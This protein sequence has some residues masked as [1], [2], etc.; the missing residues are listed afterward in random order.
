M[1]PSAPL[2]SKP[3]F[4]ERVLDLRRELRRLL[5]LLLGLLQLALEALG[6]RL[7]LALREAGLLQLLLRASHGGFGLL[8]LRLDRVEGGR[9]AL[10]DRLHGLGADRARLAGLQAVAEGEGGVLA[11]RLLL[12]GSRGGLGLLRLRFRRLEVRE[13]LLLLRDGLL[14]FVELLLLVGGALRG[15]G[16]LLL[17][18]GE[19]LG[20]RLRRDERVVAAFVVRV[21]VFVRVQLVEVAVERLSRLAGAVERG[22]RGVEALAFVRVVLREARLLLP[23]GAGLLGERRGLVERLE[24]GLGLLGAALGGLELGLLLLEG[25]LRGAREVGLELALDEVGLAPG[26][27][28][29]LVRDLLH[30]LVDREVEE[31]H[32]DLAALL[33][34]A[35][36]ERVELAL[37]QDHR[38]REAVVVEAEDAVDLGAHLLDAVGD[39][40]GRAVRD[41]L[42]PLLRGL[43]GARGAR[44]PV[45][46]LADAELEHHREPLGAVADELLVV[47]AH[48]RDLAVEREDDRVDQR[49]LAGA[50]RAGDREEVE[51]GEVEL[52]LLPEGGEA[53]ERELVRP[54]FAGGRPLVASSWTWS[55]SCCSSSDGGRCGG[56]RSRRRRGGSGR[57]S[58]GPRRR[59]S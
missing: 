22:V 11:V 5:L 33:R 8:E 54:H 48:A 30:P 36:Q 32:Q 7:A 43:V 25:L 52:D 40:L 26:R 53:F 49:R 15:S 21:R 13:R 42:E 46:L 50:G 10:R 20:E 24:R 28:A 56:A 41:P 38:A 45:A 59:S 55:K 16:A 39:R 18:G 51:A 47:V 23:M 57:A 29:P 6:A 1:A 12:L 58:R 35:L 37:R 4:F 17:E 44:D 2:A 27:R 19:L 31:G 34:L 3:A 14:R 9:L